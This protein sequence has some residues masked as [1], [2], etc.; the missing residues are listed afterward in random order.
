[1][2]CLGFGPWGT[3]LLQALEG[4]SATLAGTGGVGLGGGVEGVGPAGGGPAPRRP[5]EV[6]DLQVSNLML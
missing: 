1:M 3:S 2:M 5:A 4:S 6:V